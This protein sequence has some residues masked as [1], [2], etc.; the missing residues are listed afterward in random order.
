MVVKALR[1][2]EGA[3]EPAPQSKILKWPR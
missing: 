2:D 1:A 3:R